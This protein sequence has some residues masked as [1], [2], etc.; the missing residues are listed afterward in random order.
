MADAVR[1]FDEPRALLAL[2]DFASS[3]SGVAQLSPGELA[4]LGTQL[5]AIL[6]FTLYDSGHKLDDELPPADLSKELGLI[7]NEQQ[8]K[9]WVAEKVKRICRRFTPNENLKHKETVEFIIQYIHEHYAENI[10]LQDVADQVYISKNYLSTL[11]RQFTGET[12]GDYLT[13]VRWKKPRAWSWRKSCS[14]PKL[15]SGSDTAT[16][17]TLPR[18]SKAYRAQPDRVLP[19]LTQLQSILDPPRIQ[20]KRSRQFTDIRKILKRFVGSSATR[21]FLGLVP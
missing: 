2:E 11:F 7:E 10:H 14:S 9:A 18:C 1:T 13:R 5:F 20:D 19:G 17:R 12:F 6:S 8:W 16:F 4:A 15:P 21:M 3:D